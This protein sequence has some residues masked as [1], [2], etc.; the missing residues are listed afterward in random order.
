MYISTIYYK[1]LD[2]YTDNFAIFKRIRKVGIKQWCMRAKLF[3]SFD[4]LR[5]ENDAA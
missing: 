2:R 1:S 4:D 5:E 3:N